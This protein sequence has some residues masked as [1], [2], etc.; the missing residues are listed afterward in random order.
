VARWFRLAYLLADPFGCRCLNN[1]TLLRFHIPLF[2]PDVRFSRI[3]LSDKDS[4][5]RPRQALRQQ[6]QFHQPQRL[7]EVCVRVARPTRTVYLVLTTQ[8]PAKPL[9]HVRIDGSI[10]QFAQLSPGDAF[11]LACNAARDFR[12][13]IGGYRLTPLSRLSP[14]HALTLN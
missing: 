11:A 8:P 1:L 14:L 13:F 6:R 10:R 12:T 2:K 9:A 5:F 3:R 4:R 7:V